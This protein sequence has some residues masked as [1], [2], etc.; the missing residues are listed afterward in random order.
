MM[1]WPAGAFVACCN[2]AADMGEELFTKA[3]D[4]PLLAAADVLHTARLQPCPFGAD[5]A[6]RA[7]AKAVSA[8]SGATMLHAQAAAADSPQRRDSPAH[9]SLARPWAAWHC[10]LLSRAIV[11]E[12]DTFQG[13]CGKVAE[14]V[15]L[16]AD[17][18][19][20]ARKRRLRSLLH[21]ESAAHASASLA[22]HAY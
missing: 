3:L 21:L 4:A 22:A 20:D 15:T 9:A 5:T 18:P 16:R 14:R 12:I 13:F 1:F 19:R 17:W 2:V 10:S 11:V 7:S 6:P 8:A